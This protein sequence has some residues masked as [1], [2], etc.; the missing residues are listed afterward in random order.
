MPSPTPPIKVKTKY[1]AVDV[2][3]N[4][5]KSYVHSD[6]GKIEMHTDKRT[7]ILVKPENVSDWK[8]G[9]DGWDYKERYQPQHAPGDNYGGSDGRAKAENRKN[10]PLKPEPCTH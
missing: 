10:S 8:K 3:R 7:T 1:S 6:K 5:V 4:G 9:P 2:H